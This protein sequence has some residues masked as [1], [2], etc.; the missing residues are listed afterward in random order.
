VTGGSWDPR[1]GSTRAT[2]AISEEEARLLQ[3]VVEGYCGLAKGVGVGF[4]RKVAPRLEALGFDGFRSY[5]HHLRYDPDGPR[6]LEDLVECLTTHETYFF[7][8]GYQLEAFG[9]EIL[10][11]LWHRLRAHKR[12]TIWSAGCSTGEEVYTVAML[13]LEDPRFRGWNIRVVGT[14]LSR[15]VVAAAR[16]GNYGAAS[17]RVTEPYFLRKYFEPKGARHRV[18]DEVRALCSFGQLNLV[19]TERHRVLWPCDVV[20][21]RNVLMYL[22]ATARHRVVDSFYDTLDPGGWLLLGHSE[23]LLNVTTRF[24]IAQLSRDLVYRRPPK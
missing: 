11:E 20:F 17:F 12:L 14:D 1:G 15:R 21:C 18:R 10:A 24:E 2:V 16:E 7:R 5:Y 23:S 4:E 22:S 8:E 19:D 13:L 6:E 9:V 3:E